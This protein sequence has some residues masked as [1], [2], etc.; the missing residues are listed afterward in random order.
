M[1]TGLKFIL[2]KSHPQ[3]E[4]SYLR[5]LCKQDESAHFLYD[6]LSQ[7]H[8]SNR[9][10]KP[11]G[12]A[13]GW[14]V[15]QHKMIRLLSQDGCVWARFHPSRYTHSPVNADCLVCPQVVL[16]Q[17]CYLRQ[18]CKKVFWRALLS[19]HRAQIRVEEA[20]MKDE[21]SVFLEGKVAYIRP[22]VPDNRLVSREGTV[23]WGKV[24]IARK[25]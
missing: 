25:Q 16:D 1:P 6:C 3:A 4:L 19:H 12:T 5:E 24:G 20:M 14:L 21:E 7:T 2:E 23:G 22:P 17:G 8:Q 9:L 10:V 13:T 18:V 11:S 15:C